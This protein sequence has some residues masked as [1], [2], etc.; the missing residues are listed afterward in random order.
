MAGLGSPASDVDRTVGNRSRLSKLDA[1]GGRGYRWTVMSERRRREGIVVAR[2]NRN[3]ERTIEAYAR[4]NQISV[5]EA[6][7]RLI[8]ATRDRST[9]AESLNKLGDE[10]IRAGIERGETQANVPKTKRGE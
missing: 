2:V 6:M 4:A 7:R 5:A 8:L 1:V 3:E 9:F 10:G